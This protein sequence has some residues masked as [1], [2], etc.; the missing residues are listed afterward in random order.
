V[1]K[2]VSCRDAKKTKEL[3]VSGFWLLGRGHAVVTMEDHPS[4][5]KRDRRTEMEGAIKF[6][7]N[8]SVETVYQSEVEIKKQAGRY[9]LTVN[10]HRDIE[11]PI[12]EK[13]QA[14]LKAV[15]DELNGK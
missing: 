10:P 8:P 15:E 5:K 12:A 3:R 6:G 2:N 7:L 1:F 9:S 11:R 13:V 14:A 4:S